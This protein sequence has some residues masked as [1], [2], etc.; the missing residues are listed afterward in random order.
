MPTTIAI[1]SRLLRIAF[2]CGTIMIVAICFVA[3]AA[4]SAVAR[5]VNRGL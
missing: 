2:K 5:I 1:L 3:A 4:L